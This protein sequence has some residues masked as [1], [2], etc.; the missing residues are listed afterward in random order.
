[1]QKAKDEASYLVVEQVYILLELGTSKDEVSAIRAQ[2]FKDKKALE[3]AYEEGFDVIFNYGY[4]SCA[5][6][7][8]MYGSNPWFQ[9]G[10]QTRLSRYPLKRKRP[11]RRLMRRVL[12]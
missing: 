4:G 7:H 1:M 5:F 2:A 9:T 12:T 3:E 6:T 10:C 11:W 8:N